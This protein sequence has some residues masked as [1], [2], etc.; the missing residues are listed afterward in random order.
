M[1]SWV[2]LV[3]Q[4]GALALDFMG[5]GSGLTGHIWAW[6]W[7]LQEPLFN[8]RFSRANGVRPRAPYHTMFFSLLWR[9]FW[10]VRQGTLWILTRSQMFS[11]WQ[12]QV[13]SAQFITET[14]GSIIEGK[15]WGI[16]REY[17]GG[18]QGPCLE[19]LT[20]YCG[21]LLRLVVLC[22]KEV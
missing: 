7:K 20:P 16:A 9:L 4:P 5:I 21:L 17:S 19:C 18:Y 10:G 2:L 6:E 3:Q 8:R 15:H 11:P 1:K 14:H 13:R 12:V 22:S